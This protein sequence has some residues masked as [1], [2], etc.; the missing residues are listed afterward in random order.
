MS[1]RNTM[2]RMCFVTINAEPLDGNPVHLWSRPSQWVADE[3]VLDRY[4]K[5]TC[6]AKLVRR[7]PL[8]GRTL[9]E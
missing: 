5:G 3:N 9:Q 1:V 6:F 7:P 2:R 8:G 4:L